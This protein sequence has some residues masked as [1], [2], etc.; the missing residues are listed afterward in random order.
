MLAALLIVL[1]ASVSADA[2]EDVPA[3]KADAEAVPPAKANAEAVPPA[4]G[5]APP[6]KPGKSLWS[7]IKTLLLT[8]NVIFIAALI[9]L[10]YVSPQGSTQAAPVPSPAA[11]VAEGGETQENRGTTEG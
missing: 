1:L 8:F 6:A 4:K 7:T 10:A 3:A 5:D 2:A 11:P 9:A